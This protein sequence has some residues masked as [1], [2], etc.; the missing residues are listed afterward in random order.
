MITK[1]MI[2]ATKDFYAQNLPGWQLADRTLE[3]IKHQFD[4]QIS[5]EVCLA[6]AAAISILYGARVDHLPMVAQ[7]ICTKLKSPI[8][9]DLVERIA[10]AGKK[11]KLRSF[12]SKF[13]H[14]FIDADRYP[15]YDVA[16]CLAIQH[17]LGNKYDSR[18][19][20]CYATFCKN[21]SMLRKTFSITSS[22]RD[23]DRFLWVVGQ[24]KREWS[25][26][27][28]ELS[29]AFMND[30]LVIQK[31]LPSDLYEEKASK[32]KQYNHDMEAARQKRKR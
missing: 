24:W 2:D 14:F 5:D 23:L 30:S 29:F 19:K 6:K 17:F 4:G 16:T 11:K 3:K 25:K 12:A 15:I 1:E 22:V 9:D 26:I 32:Q 10:S 20:R 18:Q 31:I 7:S 27:N 13:C 8:G 21:V 28:R